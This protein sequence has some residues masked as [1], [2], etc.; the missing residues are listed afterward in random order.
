MSCIELHVKEDHL[1]DPISLLLDAELDKVCEIKKETAGYVWLSYDLA[2]TSKG[3][4]TKVLLVWRAK[5]L[6]R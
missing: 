6:P 1:Q 4:S 2:N 5:V 3:F